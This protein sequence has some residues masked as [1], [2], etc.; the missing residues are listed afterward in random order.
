MDKDFNDKSQ[1][2]NNNTAKVRLI[3]VRNIKST[4]TFDNLKSNAK[5][6]SQS[7]SKV[8]MI[9]AHFYA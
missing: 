6:S 2:F 3:Y 5:I 8:I 7:K 9:T 4:I 1:L